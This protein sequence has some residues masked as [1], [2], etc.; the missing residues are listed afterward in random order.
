MI[1]LQ[2][3]FND[4]TYGELAQTA[5]GG[6][7]AGFIAEADYPKAVSFVNLALTALHRRFLLKK[8]KV[9]VQQVEGTNVY[10]LR[11]DYAASNTDSL[12]TPLYLIDSAAA[13]FQDNVL[14]I[15]QVISALGVPYALNDSTIDVPIYIPDYDTIEMTPGLLPEIVS[16]TYRANYPKI[17][18]DS[19][20]NPKTVRLYIPE[21][22]REALL[23]HIAARVFAPIAAGEGETSLNRVFTSRYELECLKIENKN[24]ALEQDP[25]DTR[26]ADNGWI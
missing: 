23:C 9:A 7:A 1:T 11:Y 20:F 6:G 12:L 5:M 17:T 19:T 21:F 3:L 13:P 10:Y 24:L 22:I 18:M 15:E 8:G 2:E 25:V 4:L 26:F 16:V 14:K